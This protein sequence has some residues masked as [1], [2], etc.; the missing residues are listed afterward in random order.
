MPP[1]L[2]RLTVA[3][4][5]VFV[6]DAVGVGLLALSGLSTSDQLGRSIALGVS[7]LIA[8]PLAVLLIALAASTW[9]R[10]RLGLWICLALGLAPIIWVL[11]NSA[12]SSFS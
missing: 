10:T 2:L 9:F 5:A 3:A 12:R 1:R 11:I 6:I 7:E 8:V 4:W